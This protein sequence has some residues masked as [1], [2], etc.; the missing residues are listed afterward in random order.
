MF[1]AKHN[2]NRNVNF[3]VLCFTFHFREWIFFS[4]RIVLFDIFVCQKLYGQY[5]TT[6]IWHQI[7]Q[8]NSLFYP[9]MAVSASSMY[10]WKMQSKRQ[11]LFME[12]CEL[13]SLSTQNTV[14]S[15]FHIANPAITN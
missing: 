6:L 8:I 1:K 11:I 9:S 3:Y 14:N 2:L 10:F 7:L 15:A 12:F 5:M 4:T 13:F